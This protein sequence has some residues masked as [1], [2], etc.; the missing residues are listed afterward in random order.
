MGA[1][2]VC[3]VFGGIAIV[4]GLF[5]MV[6]DTSGFG[7]TPRADPTGGVIMVAGLI[8]IIL[9]VCCQYLEKAVKHLEVLRQAAM[10][11]TAQQEIG[12]EH[13]AEAGEEAL[14][15]AEKL[16]IQK[17][18]RVRAEKDARLRRQYNIE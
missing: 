7:P 5:A 2:V 11:N 9:G 1:A 14:S 12:R 13:K 10:Y 8:V 17:Q 6:P 18:A 15:P 4:A 16:E 3:F